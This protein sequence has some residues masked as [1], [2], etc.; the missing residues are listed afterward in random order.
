MTM[1]CQAGPS[2]SF[3]KDVTQ[4]PGTLKDEEDRTT[5]LIQ[6]RNDFQVTGPSLMRAH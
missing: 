2:A 3:T 4:L 6:A 1:A 5:L